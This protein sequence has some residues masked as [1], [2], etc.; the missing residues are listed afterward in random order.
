MQLSLAK[1]LWADFKGEVDHRL[2][3]SLNVEEKEKGTRLV[4]HPSA[5]YKKNEEY[6]NL[7][8]PSEVYREAQEILHTVKERAERI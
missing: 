5:N 1:E 4:I 7:S 3:F 6:R 2:I 8:V